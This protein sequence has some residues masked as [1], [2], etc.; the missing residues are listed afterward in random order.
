MMSC[1]GRGS[2]ISIQRRMFILGDVIMWIRLLVA[3]FFS[4]VVCSAGAATRVFEFTAMVDASD[5][6]GAPNGTLMTGR[7]G[8][9]PDRSRAIGS[10]DYRPELGAAFIEVVGSNGFRLKRDTRV[11][12]VTPGDV[13]DTMTMQ[14]FVSEDPNGWNMFIDFIEPVSS[15]WLKGDSRLPDVFPE[16][17]ADGFVSLYFTD[18]GNWLRSVD[19]TLLTVAPASIVPVP[20]AAWLFVSAVSGLA[21]ANLRFR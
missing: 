20:A 3:L 19:A 6:P 2:Y 18:E 9:D 17:P 8:Y 13:N 7:F 1:L 11:I 5:R 12:V 14:S 16:N 10:Y 21:L 4:A 15:G